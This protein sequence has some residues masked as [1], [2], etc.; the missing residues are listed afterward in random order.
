MGDAATK[1]TD[2]QSTNTEGATQDTATAEAA[3]QGFDPRTG[4]P[5][6][7]PV[8]ATAPRAVREK[9]DA[10]RAAASAWARFGPAGRAGALDAV[11]DSLDAH[12]GE[13][14]ALA[15]LETALGPV[16][17]TGEVARTT[18][19]LRMFSGL[20]R[21][22]GIEGLVRETAPAP[23]AAE[24]VLAN[25]PIGPVAVF[26]A[27]NF[28]FAFSVA[29]GDTASALA[30]GCP[31]VVKAHEAHPRTSLRTA[32][33]VTAALTAAGAPPGVFDIVFGRE[34]GGELLR[35]PALAAAGFTGSTQGGLAL[36]AICAARP[37][38][39]PF[40]G[41]L[42]SVNPVFAL[43]GAARTRPAELAAGYAGSLTQGVGQFC[44]NPGLLF[45]PDQPELLETIGTA[46]AATTG[47]PMLSERIHAGYVE[48][49]REL[50]A[51]PGVR[52]LA[53]GAPGQ[54]P[55]S[56]TPQVFVI[57]AQSYL[58]N[59]ALLSEERF[60]P[61]GLVIT[62]TF[63][64]GADLLH[65]LESGATGT[66]HLTGTIHLD[67]A[68]PVDLDLARAVTAQ[69]RT[70]VGRIVYNG[71]PTGVAVNHAQHHGGP[72]PATTAPAYTSVGST[73]ILRWLIPV[74]YQGA[75]PELGLDRPENRLG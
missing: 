59:A 11:A 22:E 19:Q 34:S 17:L 48:A 51:I 14:V 10:A 65:L 49:A 13:L 47:G 4:K 28:P 57:D 68:D 9:A 62:Y 18:G 5:A 6:G 75:P 44:T 70:L 7:E 73:A 8:P 32:E 35:H 69:L 63:D 38:P 71:W 56:G 74:V 41:E 61:I 39:I 21:E 31:V 43:P 52:P 64:A 66:G 26:A 72:Y 60:G 40:F 30:A 20:L 15:D 16:R 50:A 42:G 25:R 36:A 54:G 12:A 3:V 37:A 46:V 58:D 1:G 23:I 55:W 29:G 24:L 2:M 53:Q 45:V 27:S 67:P 33:L